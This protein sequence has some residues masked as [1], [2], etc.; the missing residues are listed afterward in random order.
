MTFLLFVIAR[1]DYGVR[2]EA[3]MMEYPVFALLS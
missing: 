3:D 1:K 2:V